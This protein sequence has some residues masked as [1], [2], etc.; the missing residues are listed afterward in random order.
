MSSNS[1]QSDLWN[2]S[3]VHTRSEEYTLGSI[4]IPS[5]CVFGAET[6][7]ALQNF[8]I[9]SHPPP[10]GLIQ[11]FLHFKRASALA[12]ERIGQLKPKERELIEASIDEFQRRLPQELP[13]LFPI[14]MY[15]SGGGHSLN[16]NS[17][18][19]IAHFA[20]KGVRAG[21]ESHSELSSY[22][23]PLPGT[24]SSS[25]RRFRASSKDVA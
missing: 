24:T 17:N 4:D 16:M 5:E 20:R 8:P 10:L 9:S 7:R 19:V 15:Q 12:H 21:E 6:Q 11:N 1:R 3:I 14:G 2:L 25:I 18:E 13:L 23:S 22:S